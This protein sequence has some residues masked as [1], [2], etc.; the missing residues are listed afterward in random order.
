[1]VTPKTPP[2]KNTDKDDTTPVIRHKTIILRKNPAVPE[3]R[4]ENDGDGDVGRS[5]AFDAVTTFIPIL[6]SS[7]KKTAPEDTALDEASDDL[8]TKGIAGLSIGC[9]AFTTPQKKAVVVPEEVASAASR[10][11]TKQKQEDDDDEWIASTESEDSESV[12]TTTSSGF[13]DS[14]VD[15]DLDWGVHDKNDEF[16]LNDFYSPENASGTFHYTVLSPDKG[17]TVNVRRSSRNSL[18]SPF[19]TND[20]T[21]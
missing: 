12:S 15:D 17:V 13:I 6:T 3:D 21:K 2:S 20:K 5:L 1:M 11:K 10:A 14:D 16:R 8:L 19:L 7:R 18:G 9:K 4:L